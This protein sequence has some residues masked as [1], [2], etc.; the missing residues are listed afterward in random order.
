MN[1]P[2]ALFIRYLIFGLGLTMNRKV[3]GVVL[4]IKSLNKIYRKVMTASWQ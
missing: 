2:A 3:S 1:V 4:R